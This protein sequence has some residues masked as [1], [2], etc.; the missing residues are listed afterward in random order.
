MANILNNQASFISP[1]EKHPG[2]IYNS[3]GENN[4]AL[5]RDP[6]ECARG[7]SQGDSEADAPDASLPHEL[8]PRCN[9]KQSGAS[10][11]NIIKS[12]DNDESEYGYQTFRPSLDKYS[13]PTGHT[14]D[15]TTSFNIPNNAANSSFYI[16]SASSFSLFDKPRHECPQPSLEWPNPDSVASLQPPPSWTIS[17]DRAPS[18]VGSPE[19]HHNRATSWVSSRPQQGIMRPDAYRPNS[20]YIESSRPIPDGPTSG[21]I[22]S[23]QPT[24]SHIFTQPLLRLYES[25]DK[26]STPRQDSPMGSFRTDI[27]NED[28]DLL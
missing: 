20:A 25:A 24:P 26:E 15:A 12:T 11:N 4:I 16:Q 23:P 3:W 28:E 27:N 21:R 2:Y 6:R 14:N 1:S 19:L 18:I 22:Y 8:A 17:A 7:N 5:T 10:P 13:P 9:E